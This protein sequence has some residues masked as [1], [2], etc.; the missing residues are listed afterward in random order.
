MGDGPWDW[1][2]IDDWNIG[3][4]MLFGPL[5]LA[6]DSNEVSSSPVA[7]ASKRDEA[8][9]PSKPKKVRQTAER[10]RFP[11]VTRDYLE[12]WIKEHGCYAT[13]ADCDHIT[14]LTG[15]T[16]RQ[17]RIYLSNHRQRCKDSKK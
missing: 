17:I 11:T 15:L 13:A 14:K 3:W 5:G 2:E 7:D 16:A 4:K 12:K 8:N 9:E 10:K 1:P 6:G